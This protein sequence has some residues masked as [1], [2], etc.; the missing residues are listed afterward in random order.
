[1]KI[2]GKSFTLNGPQP[3]RQVLL[4]RGFDPESVALE[5]NKQ[6][7]RRINFDDTIVEDDDVLEVFSFTG[8]G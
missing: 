7:I 2:N 4:D 3:L 5:K 8:V 1:M 6:L